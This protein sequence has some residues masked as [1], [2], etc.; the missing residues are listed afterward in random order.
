V[1]G[2][3]GNL[4]GAMFAGGAYGLGSVFELSGISP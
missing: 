1:L 2:K 3:D 4:N